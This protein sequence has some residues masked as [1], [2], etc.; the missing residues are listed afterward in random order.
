MFGLPSAI[1]YKTIEIKSLIC[2][3]RDCAVRS[4]KVLV[5]SIPV[6]SCYFLVYYFLNKIIIILVI[7]FITL[8]SFSII[9]T[10][11][12]KN[13][14]IQLFYI[15]PYLNLLL[16]LSRKVN[17]STLYSRQLYNRFQSLLVAE[18]DFHKFL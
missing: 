6:K 9:S 10:D 14:I 16:V 2:Y 15:L 17:C 1:Y 3:T 5:R 18:V 7:H 11:E 12:N 13:V 4:Y 8:S